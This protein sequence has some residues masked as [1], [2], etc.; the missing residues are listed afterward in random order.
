ML[1]MYF[2]CLFKI[3]EERDELY[4]QFVKS[5]HEVQQKSSFK[6]LL[7]EKKM[8]TLGEL[9]EQKEGQLNEILSCSNLDPSAL[10][11]ITRKLE[12]SMSSSNM[13]QPMTNPNTPVKP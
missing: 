13:R 9:L 1:E 10:S 3:Q 4:S 11:M 6:N 2:L 5:I 7:L 12:V 8:A